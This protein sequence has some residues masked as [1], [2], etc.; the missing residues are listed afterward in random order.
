[1]ISVLTSILL[2]LYLGIV[3]YRWRRGTA[4][5]DSISRAYNAL[6]VAFVSLLLTHLFAHLYNTQTWAKAIE[7]IPGVIDIFGSVT[8]VALAICTEVIL[9]KKKRTIGSRVPS[10]KC[11]VP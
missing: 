4:S 8:A 6:G 1:M 2:Y 9:R 11:R 7:N 10:T 3:R 5:Q